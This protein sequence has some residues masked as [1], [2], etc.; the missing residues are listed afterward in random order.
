MIIR[1][2]EKKD[3]KEVETL[4]REAFWNVYRPGCFEHL[5]VHKIREDKC[6]VKE[7][8]YVIEENHKIVANIIYAK[9]ELTLKDGSTQDTLLFGPISVLPEYQNKGYGSEIIKYTLNKAKEL[10]Y[11]EVFITGNPQYYHR[12][13]FESA[14]KY[15]IYHKEIGQDGECPVFMINILNKDKFNINEAIYSDPE[16]YNISEDE[17]E[18]FEKQFPKKEKRKD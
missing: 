14:S 11:S 5:V 2:E 18:E 17:L 10:G 8:D 9:G 15:K 6:F 4:T 13:G 7:L 3:Y 16:I 1:L 12:F